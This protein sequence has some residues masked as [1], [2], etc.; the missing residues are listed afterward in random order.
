LI[1]LC[2]IAFYSSAILK[3][4]I[5]FLKNIPDF[6]PGTFKGLRH[7]KKLEVIQALENFLILS[8][9]YP[10]LLYYGRRLADTAS[11]IKPILPHL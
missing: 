1:R 4:K 11:L 5:K 9:S 3:I 8:S 6:R 2:S 10:F 7:G